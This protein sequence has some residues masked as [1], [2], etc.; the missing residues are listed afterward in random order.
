TARRNSNSRF[1]EAIALLINNK[2]QL[3]SQLT[4]ADER[5]ARTN[6]RFA[7]TDER[8][9]RIEQELADIKT[10]LLRHEQMLQAL[11]EAIPPKRSASTVAEGAESRYY[12][13]AAPKSQSLIEVRSVHAARRHGLLFFGDLGNERLGCQHQAGNRR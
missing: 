8:R 4:R 10:I 12:R 2:A 7:R 1:E 3:V 6:E 13:P 11:P 9:G 5:A